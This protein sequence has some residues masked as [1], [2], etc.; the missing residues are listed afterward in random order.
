MC[1]IV[2]C[3]ELVKLHVDAWMGSECVDE[4]SY[5]FIVGSSGF[6]NDE[7]DGRSIFGDCWKFGWCFVYESVWKARCRVK[8]VKAE[9][10]ESE[11]GRDENG[12]KPA[13]HHLCEMSE[14]LSVISKE[15]GIDRKKKTPKSVIEALQS[16]ALLIVEFRAR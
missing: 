16:P 10:D 2:T 12:S 3:E 11:Y 7:G 5:D 14:G 1:Y 8:V 13:W 15:V 9:E 4:G 6:G